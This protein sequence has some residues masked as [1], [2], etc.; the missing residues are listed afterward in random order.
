MRRRLSGWRAGAVLVGLL[1]WWPQD[2]DAQWVPTDISALSGATDGTA[3][4]I[5][6]NG[7]VVG[8]YVTAGGAQHAFVWSGGSGWT[9]FGTPHAFLWS[10]STGIVVDLNTLGGTTTAPAEG[11]FSVTRPSGRQAPAGSIWAHSAARGVPHTASTT[12]VK[13]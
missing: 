12:P 4:A 3:T 2:A 1:A 5:S 9:E 8:N 11:I 6:D 7:W 13:S 10:A